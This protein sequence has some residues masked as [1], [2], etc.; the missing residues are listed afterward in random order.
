V[1]GLASEVTDE[2]S[3]GQGWRRFR[4]CCEVRERQK[5][6]RQ[7]QDYATERGTFLAGECASLKDTALFF[8]GIECDE[9][10]IIWL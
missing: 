1:E 2:T 10:G 6:R 4:R 9:I 8:R 3:G 5:V 7:E